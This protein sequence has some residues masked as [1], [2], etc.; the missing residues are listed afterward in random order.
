MDTSHTPT[1]TQK[2]KEILNL[3]YNAGTLD[4]KMLDFNHV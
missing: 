4:I 1:L 2:Q 3:L